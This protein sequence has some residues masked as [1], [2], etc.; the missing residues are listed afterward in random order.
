MH[1]VAKTNEKKQ[2]YISVSR[3]SGDDA[4]KEL[5]QEKRKAEFVSL[6]IYCA[7]L[8]IIANYKDKPCELM[9]NKNLTIDLYIRCIQI[10]GTKMDIWRKRGKDF[11]IKNDEVTKLVHMHPSEQP[12]MEPLAASYITSCW[13]NLKSSTLI[14]NH[15]VFHFN[16]SPLL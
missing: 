11:L 10:G 6:K 15:I 12:V 3:V 2:R 4:I 9:I 5:E 16:Q 1:L 14:Q 13:P 7:L 8:V